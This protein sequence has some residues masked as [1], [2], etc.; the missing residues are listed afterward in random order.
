MLLVVNKVC[1]GDGWAEIPFKIEMGG[2]RNEVQWRQVGWWM[3]AINGLWVVY[4]WL[5]VIPVE[6]STGCM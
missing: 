6:C 5:N 1:N 2:P 4:Y 3:G